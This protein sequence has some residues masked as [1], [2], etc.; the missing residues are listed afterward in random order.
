MSWTS[1]SEIMEE[2]YALRSELDH[3][4]HAEGGLSNQTNLRLIAIE[5]K[6]AEM[7][8]WRAGLLNHI[9]V[10]ISTPAASSTQYGTITVTATANDTLGHGIAKLEFFIDELKFAEDAASPF[11]VT[12]DTTQYSNASHVL[13]VNA[14]CTTGGWGTLSESITINNVIPTGGT[15]VGGGTAAYGDKIT[16]GNISPTSGS[17]LPMSFT[18][19]VRA[20]CSVGHPI[21]SVTCGGQNGSYVTDSKAWYLPASFDSTSQQSKTFTIIATC[22]HGTTGSATVTYHNAD[23][24]GSSGWGPTP[25]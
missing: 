14:Y 18:I 17:T 23:Y 8:L 10:A 4:L 16:I 5:S 19:Q 15:T 24:R 20:E 7:D 13:K 3:L 21:T 22:A 6:L 2:L 1:K 12:L 25:V 9:V 11:T